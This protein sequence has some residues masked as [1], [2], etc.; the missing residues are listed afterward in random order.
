MYIKSGCGVEVMGQL[1]KEEEK[2]IL[3]NEKGETDGPA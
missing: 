3:K 1:D 2:E